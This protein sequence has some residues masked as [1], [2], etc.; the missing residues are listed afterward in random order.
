M[1]DLI[2]EKAKTEPSLIVSEW[3]KNLGISDPAFR[4]RIDIQFLI[5][6]NS[7]SVR[8]KPKLQLDSLMNNQRDSFPGL[9][10]KNFFLHN[11]VN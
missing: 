2:R 8:Y 3:L 5:T 11:P 10:E 7:L 6:E 9:W 4:H 1:A